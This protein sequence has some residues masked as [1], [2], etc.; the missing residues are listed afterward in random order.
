MII[1]ANNMPRK[2]N[3]AKN[4]PFTLEM[5]EV[6]FGTIQ[7]DFSS[8]REEMN[9]KFEAVYRRFEKIDERF[10]KIDERFEKIDERFGKV[11]G[12]LSSILKLNQDDKKVIKSTLWEHGRRLIRL[13]KSLS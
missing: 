3:K 2:A 10:E 5:A 9:S 7:N 12:L 8:L 13:E 1:K 11:E 4:T 6:Y